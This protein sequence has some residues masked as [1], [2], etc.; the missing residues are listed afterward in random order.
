VLER[1]GA[2]SGGVVAAQL[3]VA[4]GT[5]G[6]RA[7]EHGCAHLLE[8][9]VFKPHQVAGGETDLALAIEE[10]G[11]DVNAF[12]SHD[13]TVYHVTVPA[14]VGEQGVVA[15]LDA[16]VSPRIDPDE[17]ARER[18]VVIEEIRQYA[19][20]PGS[21]AMQVLVELLFR[22][23]AYARPVLG[24][25]PEVRRHL[26]DVVRR[27]HRE[28]YAGENLCL[29]VAGPVDPARMWSAARPRLGRAP[30][31]RRRLR[32]ERPPSPARPQL[33]LLARDVREVSIRLGWTG[34]GVGDADAIALD[35][36]AIALGQ[37][38]ASR[39]V[40]RTRRRD[41]LVS[42][43]HASFMPFA[44]GGALVVSAQTT[45]E[46][47][48][49]AVHALLHEIREPTR[50]PLEPEEFARARA[51]LE[52][53]LVYRRETVQG[54]AHTAGHFATTAGSLEAEAD[55]YARLERTTPEQ[56]CRA[57]A[58]HLAPHRTALVVLA[59][60]DELPARTRRRLGSALRAELRDEPRVRRRT[61]RASASGVVS[62]DLASGLRV[63]ALRVRD[64]PIAA[65]WLMWA[66]GLRREPARW[67][68]IAHLAAT[69]LV[70]GCRGHDGDALAREID[71]LAA[72]LEGFSGR[73]S[74]GLQFECLAQ[75]VPTVLGRAFECALAPT[76][77]ADELD[78]ERRVALDDLRAEQDDLGQVAYQLML[79]SLYGAHPYHRNVRGT[80][81]T[82]GA[83]DRDAIARLWKRDYPIGHAV[84]GLAGDFDLDVVL[85][86]IDEI[87]ARLGPAP[88]AP[89]RPLAGPA[90]RWPSRARTVRARRRREQAHLVVGYPGL[91]MSDAR[92]PALDVLL[93]ILGGQ[94]GRLFQSL[95][96]REGLVYQVGA[97]STEGL[98]AGHVTIY[99]AT[100]QNRRDRAL[101]AIDGELERIRTGPLEPG[102]LDR[103][104]A[105]LC[106]QHDVGNQR[107]ARVASHLAF[108]EVYGLGTEHFLR[109][110]HRIER[111]G[112]AAVHRVARE[113]LD[114]ERRV[115]AI[116]HA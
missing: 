113:L 31:R 36:L 111:V 11:G 107:R 85:A 72:V 30:A 48:V 70:R 94:S 49:A 89:R 50:V 59:P 38:D 29:V 100:G 20:E 44:R 46:R 8:H 21:V 75:H 76:F 25:V 42:D 79:R 37:G 15:L 66:G 116:V 5:C 88:A 58:H 56:V 45:T 93:T 102:E 2:A 40:S 19:D 115:V 18:R 64:V 62:V 109:Y 16:V 54:Q 60:R 71:G 65:G 98:D 97:T 47:C 34:P 26:P 53:G 32:R 43:V 108:G 95:R 61:G 112:A 83:I 87:V 4:A 10:L 103:A 67:A 110:A 35:V 14:R 17:L 9:M 28:L 81:A 77:P 104:K 84:L 55:Y 1:D 13:E 52:S 99:A 7:D 23:D 105:Y 39:L 90:P 12:T 6:E 96:E 82:L 106:G 57:A 27:V 92:T 73:N 86:R 41:R 22:G 114:P 3:W 78:G 33:R 101:A 80:P 91:A 68:G 74:L 51:V 69:L 63:R 24:R